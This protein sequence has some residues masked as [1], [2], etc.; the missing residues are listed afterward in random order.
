MTEFENAADL[1]KGRQM[2]SDLAHICDCG[3][4][5]AGTQS[6]RAASVLLEKLGAQATGAACQP[7]SVPYSGWRAKKA[8]LLG[9]G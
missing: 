1:Q 9:P 7:I 4:R 8:S 3:G 2:L 5:L 6:E